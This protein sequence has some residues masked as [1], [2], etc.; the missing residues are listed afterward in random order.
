MTPVSVWAQIFSAYPLKLYQINPMANRV[1]I[2][3]Q[4]VTEPDI[5]REVFLDATIVVERLTNVEEV[6]EVTTDADA[7][8]T[9]GYTPVT[10]RV[11]DERPNLEVIARAGIGVDNI[12]L[13]A[14]TRTGTQVVNVPTYCADEVAMHA[15]ALLFG[16]V[17]KIR[18]YDESV[19]R[20]SWDW[21]SARPVHRF[22]GNTLGIVGF[23]STGKRVAKKVE[24]FDVDI[25]AHSP[26]TP[27]AEMAEY[28]VRKVD[29]D[30]LLQESNLVSVHVPLTHETE[31][32][33][34]RDAFARMRDDAIF[35]NTAR[36]GVVDE[37]ALHDAVAEGDIQGAG[38]DVMQD[39]PPGDSSL[40]DLEDI[41][42]TPHVAWYSEEGI[43]EVRRHAA[44]Q[45]KQ[46][47]QN[48]SPAN[49][50]NEV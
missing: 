5:E 32:L 46:V 50:V 17:R 41:V 47:L 31:D 45:V 36:G 3:D 11:L 39:E 20:G 28:G 23:G 13:E 19:R 10:G 24:G 21:E 7:L 1:V 8:I 6:L 26:R 40:L 14:A 22:R 15:L 27:A 18:Q 48:Q 2:S 30:E 9:D 43:N 4:K 42:V 49:P 29:F 16:C 34:D 37:G 44:D 12:D 35:V 25:V 38:L 33:F